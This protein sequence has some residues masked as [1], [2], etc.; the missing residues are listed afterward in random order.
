[1]PRPFIASP[2]VNPLFYHG[3][4]DSFPSGH[5]SA[6]FSLA[7]AMFYYLP[8]I[9]LPAGKAGFRPIWVSLFFIGAILIGLARIVAAVH[10]PVDILAGAV[11][12]I[13]TAFIIVKILQKLLKNL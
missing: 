3:A 6:F 5:A 8:Q 4:N 13:I 11:L 1:M 10:W 12:G 7:T 9:N 2:F